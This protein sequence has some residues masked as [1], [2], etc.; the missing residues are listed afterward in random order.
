MYDFYAKGMVVNMLR[1]FYRAEDYGQD[2]FSNV[3][4]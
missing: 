2:Y 1:S 3:G 4:K